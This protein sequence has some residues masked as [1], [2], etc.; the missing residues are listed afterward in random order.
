[1]TPDELS[2]LLAPVEAA[3]IEVSATAAAA[4]IAAVISSYRH[5]G[6]EQQGRIAG[7]VVSEAWRM[8]EALIAEEARVRAALVEDPHGSVH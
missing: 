3:G 4:L 8:Y 7:L 5:L 6:A 2:R 1:M